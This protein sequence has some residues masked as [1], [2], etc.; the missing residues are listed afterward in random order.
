M[1][2]QGI[3]RVLVP[4]DSALANALKAV[5]DWRVEYEDNL[6]AVLVKQHTP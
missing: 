5:P 4:R 1:A 3:A 2:R 6:S